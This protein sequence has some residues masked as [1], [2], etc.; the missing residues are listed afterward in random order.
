MRWLSSALLL[1]LLAAVIALILQI[2]AGNVA[3]LV[4]PYRVDVS[5]NLF[6]VA[7][8]VLLGAVYWIARAIQKVA[9][10]PEQVRLYR[11]RREEVGGQQALIEAVKSLLEGRFARAERA[12][13]AAQSSDTTAGVAALIGAR[14]AHRMQEYDRRDEWLQR[15]ESETAMQTAR[16]VASAEMWTEQRENDL[17]LDAIDRLQG[18]GARHIHATRIALNANLQS[19]RWEEALKAVRLLE[20]RNALHPVLVR[21]L[22]HSIYRELMLA[23]RQDPAALEAFWRRL[24]E[25]DRNVPEFA[26][27]GARMLNLAGRGQLAAEVIEAALGKSPTAWD[28][29]AERL[30]DEYARAQSFPARHQLERSEGWLA[31]APAR[32]AIRAALLRTAGLVCLREQLWGKSK[33]YLQDSL[34]EAKHPSTFLALARLAEA[35]GDEAEAARQ[36]REAALGFTQLPSVPPPESAMAGLR[37]GVREIPH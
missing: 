33:G 13:R 7:V 11:T 16:L 10:F 3:F 30:L 14:A 37:S 32:G 4:Y 2:N 18:A 6:I 28:D 22:K 1:A 17:A 15:A 12:A 25:A 5:L 29:V 21:K 31:Q 24:P 9:D 36:Y 26:L 19:G 8:V 27:E 20:K 23:Q 34:A 35:V